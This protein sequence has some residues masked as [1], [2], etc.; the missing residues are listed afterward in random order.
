M[1]MNASQHISP[2]ENWMWIALLVLSI[3]LALVLTSCKPYEI[4]TE[5]DYEKMMDK[6]IDSAFKVIRPFFFSI[7]NP[8]SVAASE[9]KY[10]MVYSGGRHKYIDYYEYPEILRKLDS[11]LVYMNY[12]D[13]ILYRRDTA[14]LYTIHRYFQQYNINFPDSN[15]LF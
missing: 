9:T 4:T 15:V 8:D 6:K 10:I 13:T 7:Y 14:T 12:I 5:N 11:I 2:K 3:S 1:T